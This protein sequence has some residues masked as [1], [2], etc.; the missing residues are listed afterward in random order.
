MICRRLGIIAALSLVLAFPVSASMVSFLVV[1]TGINEDA[2]RNQISSLWEGGVMAAFFDAGFIVTDSPIARIE[3]K[4][5]AD[6]SGPIEVDFNEAASQG[7]EFFVLGFMDFQP[8]AGRPEP[9]S[10][11]LKI[12]KVNSKKLIAEQLFPVGI[13]KSA[14]EEHRLAQD[15]GRAMITHISEK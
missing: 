3:K 12:Y 5:S 7:A 8:K 2:P 9:V 11:V 6:L 13:A 15:A 14:V 4:P 10:I 1:E